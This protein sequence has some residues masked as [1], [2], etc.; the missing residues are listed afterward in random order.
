MFMAYGDC[1]GNTL[2]QL[3]T[4]ICRPQAASLS[5]CCHLIP[6]NEQAMLSECIKA[7]QLYYWFFIQSESVPFNV[8]ALEAYSELP[9][10]DWQGRRAD[11]L[12]VGWYQAKPYIAIIELRH[13]LLTEKQTHNKLEQLTATIETLLLKGHLQRWIEQG[14]LDQVIWPR[15]ALTECQIIG[16]IIPPDRSKPRCARK[17]IVQ[18]GS[19]T[20][21][22]TSL[23]TTLLKQCAI[24]WDDLLS[25]LHV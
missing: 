1:S 14:G 13:V 2:P 17:K 6:I 16:F 23:P 15:P 25:T 21:V 4:I 9:H 5:D 3:A 10:I 24:T 7:N 20:I 22:I 19:H 18:I 11:Y 8:C 12:A